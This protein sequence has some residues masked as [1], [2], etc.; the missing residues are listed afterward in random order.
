MSGGYDQATKRVRVG[1]FGSLNHRRVVLRAERIGLVVDDLEAGLLEQRPSGVGELDAEVVADINDGDL[2]ADL[3]AVLQLFEHA[4]RGLGVVCRRRIE[5][6]EV[7][8]TS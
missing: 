1:C 7:R 4:D 8:D 2:V 3:A 5:H 6:E